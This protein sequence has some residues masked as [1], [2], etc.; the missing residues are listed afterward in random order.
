MS[1]EFSLDMNSKKKTP[2]TDIT[3]DLIV[4]G[5]GPTG[6]NGALYAKRKGLNVAIIGKRLGG[7]VLDTSSVENYMGFEFLTGEELVQKFKDHIINLEIPILED[8]EIIDLSK[9]DIF[10]VKVT[11]GSNYKAKTILLA[12]GSKPRRLGIEGEDEFLGRGVAY[13]AICDGPLF[14]GMDVIV[15][16]GGNSAVEAA[17]DMSKIASKVK[18]V[19]RS[20]LKADKILIDKL[21]SIENIEVYLNTKMEKISGD[22]MMERVHAKDKD[23]NDV[24][25]E[26]SGLFVEIGYNPNTELVKDLVKLNSKKE[27][28]VDELNKTSVEGLFAAGDVTNS[29]YKQIIISAGDGAKAALAINDYI[30]KL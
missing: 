26:S 12:T 24:I 19:H 9:N 13:C 16:G 20:E 4:I 6:M 30:N 10:N 8:E 15:A 29:P 2:I 22:F 3:Y 21:M 18:L 1:F 17:I 5:G 14:Q 27:I 23:N 25:I 7:Q 11:S 28:I